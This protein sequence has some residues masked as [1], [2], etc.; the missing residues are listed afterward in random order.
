MPAS[1]VDLDRPTGVVDQVGKVVDTLPWLSA[2]PDLSWTQPPTGKRMPSV[3]T[4]VTI[5]LRGTVM[6]QL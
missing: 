3:V 5:R 2:G 4:P 6:T 1:A